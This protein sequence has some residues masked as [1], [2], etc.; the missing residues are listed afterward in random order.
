MGKVNAPVVIR[1]ATIDDVPAIQ[2]VEIAAG[3]LFR[4]VDDPRIARCADDP[5]YATAELESA[6]IERR[7]WV[8]I[9][10]VGSIIGC[11]VASVVDDEGHLDELAVVPASGRRGVGRALVD[12]VVSWTAARQLTSITLTTF[13]DV[14][15]N[16]P[17]YEKFGFRVVTS[18]TPTLQA[19]VDKQAV[20]GLVPS[21]R[22]VMRRPL[23]PRTT[24]S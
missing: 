11:A 5:P 22:V 8:A 4:G 16:G 21:L 6:C 1:P 14:P 2:A 17:Y 3:E 12:E 7:A 13:R 19:L 18:L 24:R 20:L 9:N 23:P 15:W 10:D